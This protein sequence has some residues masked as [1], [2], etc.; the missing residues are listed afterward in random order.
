MPIT[1]HLFLR[2]GYHVTHMAGV[3]VAGDQ[4]NN[5][6]LAIPAATVNTESRVLFHGWFLGLEAL[7]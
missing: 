6:D 4:I 2:G 7:W 3:A 1:P 5:T